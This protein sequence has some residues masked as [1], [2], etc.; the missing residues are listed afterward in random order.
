MREIANRL[1]SIYID[2]PV[3]RPG[4]VGAYALAFVLAGV[5]TALQVAIDP[6]VLGA[7]YIALLLAVVITTLI[8]GLGAGLFCLAI[9]IAAVN[10]FLLEPH[11]SFYVELFELPALLLF[12]LAGL[13]SVIL[14]AGMR[15]A[16]ERKHLHES[17]A[18]LQLALDTA[19]L[20]WWAEA[21]ARVSG[22][23]ARWRGSLDRGALAWVFQWRPA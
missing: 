11:Y 19:Q 5:A 21:T 9:S 15:F 20:G 2:V 8:S 10:F 6:Y 14:I 1:A 13:S 4:T 22:S 7:R 18:H 12:I 17:K 23:A 3:L 16:I